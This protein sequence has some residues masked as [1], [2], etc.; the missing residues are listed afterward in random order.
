MRDPEE[1]AGIVLVGAVLLFFVRQREA[2]SRAASATLR[3][4]T[5]VL[6]AQGEVIEAEPFDPL[7]TPERASRAQS[8]SGRIERMKA[9]EQAAVKRLE[10]EVYRDKESPAFNADEVNL[11]LAEGAQQIRA[12]LMNKIADVLDEQQ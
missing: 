1:L 10:E 5:H 12:D 9:E 3:D 11:R 8:P 2:A 4:V 7:A 6:P